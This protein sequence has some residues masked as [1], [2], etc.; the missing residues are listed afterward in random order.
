MDSHVFCL[1]ML[2]HRFHGL[3]QILLENILPQI[4]RI[5]TDFF[6]LHSCNSCY[7]CS[8]ARTQHPCE[9]AL[10]VGE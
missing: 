8:S 3:S 2:S 6:V 10:S 5:P 9:S 1:R 7:S 4:S